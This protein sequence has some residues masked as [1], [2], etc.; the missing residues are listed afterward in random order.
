ME[1]M[2]GKYMIK[3]YEK[4]FNKRNYITIISKEIVVNE[5]KF[6]LVFSSGK[7]YVFR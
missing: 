5:T 3:M 4:I 6:F 1:L 7:S 2:K